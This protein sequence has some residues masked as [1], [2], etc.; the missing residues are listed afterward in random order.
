MLKKLYIPEVEPEHKNYHQAYTEFIIFISS[1]EGKIETT[2]E[3]KA[4]EPQLIANIEDISKYNSKK[5]RVTETLEDIEKKIMTIAT[6]LNNAKRI[7]L[8]SDSSK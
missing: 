8:D 7:R 6:D 3:Q 4:G 2:H 5:I 1:S